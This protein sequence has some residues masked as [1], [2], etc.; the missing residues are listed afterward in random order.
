MAA[1]DS[2]M[3]N[4]PVANQRRQQQA[5]AATDLQLQQAVRAAP[6]KAAT[7][8]VAQALGAAA[9]QN[10]GQQMIEAA[11]SN[12]QTAQQVGQLDLEKR[13]QELSQ[14]L[15]TLRRGVDTQQLED[16]RAFANL[17]EQAKRDMF[18]NRMQFQKDEMGREFLN[19]RQLADYAVT[20]A[21]SAEQLRDYTQSAEQLHDRK[22]QAMEAAQAKINQELEFQNTLSTQKQDQTL[23][24]QLLQAKTDLEKKIAKEKSDRANRAGTFQTIGTIAGG[25]AGAFGGPAGAAAGASA[26]GAL[27]GMA[28]A[29][30]E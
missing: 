21:R 30:T 8:Q 2:I 13:Q 3:N 16:E 27:G 18:D 10:V 26:G 19:E 5:Q 28:A 20:H 15:D 17:N 9:Q 1:L 14:R 7:P 22:M 6:P 4:M 12:V 25:A 11:K 29:A 23:K 24:K